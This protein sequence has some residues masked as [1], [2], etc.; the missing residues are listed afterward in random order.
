MFGSRHPRKGSKLG[1][2]SSTLGRNLDFRQP[3]NRFENY[4]SIPL[5]RFRAKISEKVLKALNRLAN[6]VDG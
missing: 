2:L 6:E 4:R 1:H 3:S 5:G